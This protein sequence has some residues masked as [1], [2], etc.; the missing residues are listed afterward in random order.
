MKCVLCKVRDTVEMRSVCGPCK[1]ARTGIPKEL[2]EPLPFTPSELKLKKQKD[3]PATVR[4]R[5]K[6]F[7]GEQ[8]CDWNCS[9]IYCL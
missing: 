2:R 9:S 6:K 8:Y 7:D 5:F 3:K 1:R 4:Q